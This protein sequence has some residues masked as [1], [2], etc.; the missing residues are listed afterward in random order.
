MAFSTIGVAK[1]KGGS[2]G[3][4]SLHN[5]R[6][7]ET[8]NA[9]PERSHLNRVLIGDD[10]SAQT[11]V[12][13]II[14]EHGGKPRRDSVEAV[15]LLLSASH[16]YFEGRDG[17]IDEGRLERW[18]ERS[19]RF[20]AD[21]GN[22]G[23]CAK[24]VLHL[25]ERTPHIHAHM[26]PVTEDGRLSATHFLDGR[27][28]MKEL[29]TRYN[30]Y[31]KDLGLERGREGSRATHQRVKQFYRSIKVNPELK[32]DPE[33]IPDPARLKMLTAEGAR[34]YKLEVLNHVLDQLKEPI[35]ILQDQ[36]KLTKDE[37]AHRVEADKRADAA[38][39]LAAERIEAAER[40]V[41]EKIAEGLRGAED[42]FNNLHRSAMSL[43]EENKEIRS[44]RND[45]LRQRNELQQKLLKEGT[46]K[47]EYMLQARDL[48]ERLTDIPM[49]E[50]MSHLD[51]EG[52][53]HGHAYI[54]RGEENV[55]AMR[56]EQQ[57]AYD[58]HNQLICRNSVDLVVHMREFNEGV[59]G[60]SKDEAI[61]WL[62]DEFG[63]RR[64][65]GAALVNREQEVL[66]I[67][68]RR[69]EEHERTRPGQERDD[70]W[71]S[72]GRDDGFERTQQEDLSHERD[73]GYSFDR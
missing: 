71:R 64:A 61:E 14:D 10:R 65:A 48:G 18:V 39:R 49:P 34:Q 5:G 24:A 56:I 59:Q 38:E 15:E 3:A 36:A 54:Y 20:L 8:P 51:Y 41:Q 30:T 63:D 7:R 37:H 55:I 70:S 12:R 21:R 66:E 22:C 1:Q 25:D 47:L 17:E 69:R 6:E 29:H 57:K 35:R 4:S 67:F 28:K 45:L 27:K 32:I 40:G 53:R 73:G 23:I 26:V 11:R 31:V 52:E 58:S 60:F 16:E 9:D 43:L 46:E 33:R 72:M 13:E 62:R 44:D 50:V 2:V 19:V 42:R 68:E